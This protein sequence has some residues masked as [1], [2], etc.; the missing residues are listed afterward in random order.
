M[1]VEFDAA[2]DAANIA[3]HGLALADFGGFDAQPTVQPDRRYDYSEDRFRAWGWIAGR[4]FCIA[5]TVRD[6][7]FRLISFRRAHDKE[8]RRNGQAAPPA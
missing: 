3:K 5:Y 2:K 4:G 8:M 6:T 7:Q 1:A